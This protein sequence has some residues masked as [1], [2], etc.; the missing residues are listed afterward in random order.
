MLMK[1]KEKPSTRK[2]KSLTNKMRI[3][4]ESKQSHK[5]KKPKQNN[6]NTT[7]SHCSLCISLFLLSFIL[8]FS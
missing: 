6:N 2:K 3:R 8:I 7:C 1:K 4:M 5:I